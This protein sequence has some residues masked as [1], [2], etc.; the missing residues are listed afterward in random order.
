MKKA[1]RGGEGPQKA[2]LSIRWQYLVWSILFVFPSLILEIFFILFIYLFI[3]NKHNFHLH[4]IFAPYWRSNA[5]NFPNVGLLRCSILFYSFQFYCIN[6]ST[7]NQNLC[8]VL[9]LSFFL[10][11]SLL[12]AS[13]HTKIWLLF[14]SFSFPVRGGSA[15]QAAND[16]QVEGWNERQEK[17]GIF[18]QHPQQKHPDRRGGK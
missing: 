15:A 3:F 7:S 13:L 9:F 2:Q 16:K 5:V 17:R 8:L 6:T 10:V 4:F 18:E 11:L 12:T 14:F 1:G